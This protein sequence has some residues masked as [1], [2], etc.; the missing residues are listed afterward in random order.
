MAKKEILERLARHEIS[1]EEAEQ[2]MNRPGSEPENN[3]KE[4]SV[5]SSVNT[6]HMIYLASVHSLLYLVLVYVFVFVVPD[7]KKI[8]C[9][10]DISLPVITIQFLR[11]SQILI[12]YGI[13]IIPVLWIGL[14]TTDIL[15]YAI[16]SKTSNIWFKRGYIW[17]SCVL[18]IAVYILLILSLILPRAS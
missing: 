8:F 6:R 3:A 7:F 9:E 5:H 10:L 18:F 12:K 4:Q 15:I 11:V 16:L 17:I 2:M 1:K 14:L 13:I